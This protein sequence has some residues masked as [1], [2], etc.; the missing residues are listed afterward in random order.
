[1][2]PHMLSALPNFL[3]YFATAIALLFAF[4]LIYITVTPYDEITLVNE[5]NVAAAISLAGAMLGFTLPIANVIAH[6][7]TLAELAAWSVVAG[8]I[9]LLVHLIARFAF[10]KLAEHILHG[11]IAPAIFIAASAFV[12]GI[13]NA[14]CMTY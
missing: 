13:L 11:K 4:L 2:T 12:V 10:P 6:S 14:A 9:Q 5:G 8:A 3:S 1:M 7:D